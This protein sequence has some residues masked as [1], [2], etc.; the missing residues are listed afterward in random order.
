MIFS[1]LIEAKKNISRNLP[2]TK[3]SSLYRLLGSKSF[4]SASERIL[5]FIKRSYQSL[6]FFQDDRLVSRGLFF[7]CGVSLV[8]LTIA[9]VKFQE[10]SSLNLSTIIPLP[11]TLSSLSSPSHNLAVMSTYKG[12]PVGKLEVFNVKNALATVIYIPQYHKNPGTTADDPKNDSAQKAQGEIYQILNF[13]TKQPD[14]DFIMEE[15][16]LYGKVGVEKVM[17]LADKIQ[18]RNDLVS[19]T[20]K[21]EKSFSQE[22]LDN[23]LE[24]SLISKLKD[25]QKKIDREIILSGAPLKLKAEGKEITLYGSENPQ[26]L[27][28]SKVLVKDYLYL[29][30]RLS[31]VNNPSTG[32]NVMGLSA[33]D[34]T[35]NLGNSG[36]GSDYKALLSLLGQNNG[37][38]GINR[39][40]SSL[41]SLA[42]SHNNKDLASLLQKTESAY[43]NLENVN[44]ASSV[45][46]QTTSA[47][48]GSS[49]SD[50]PY[51]SI[52]DKAQLEEKL[53]Q[54]ETQIN[55]LIVDR[56]NKET[57]QNMADVLKQ[58]KK[59]IGILQFGAG[60]EEGLVKELNKQG[61][62][63]IVITPNEAVARAKVS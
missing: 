59:P 56:R 23:G 6:R 49:R 45:L 5:L 48:S 60:H 20:A 14:I 40:F 3:Q 41:E 29:Q 57:A 4:W 38:N 7:L 19:L 9:G 33:S 13:L 24:N 30:D 27:E 39:D 50:N 11:K 1:K 22:S 18:K 35:S 16:D 63:V 46:T 52:N 53:K 2:G 25:E 47:S 26:T 32:V 55:S 12:L 61:L 42:F 51:A 54:D 10:K 43:N 31:Q 58:E 62:S 21:L 44:S 17:T 8:A 34:K 28:E 37:G 36:M 15:G